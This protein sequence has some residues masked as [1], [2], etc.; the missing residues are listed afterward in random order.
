MTCMYVRIEIAYVD[1]RQYIQISYEVL[2]SVDTILKEAIGCCLCRPLLYW[3]DILD[4]DTSLWHLSLIPVTWQVYRW[5]PWYWYQSITP[6]FALICLPFYFV[7]L[8]LKALFELK[9]QINVELWTLYGHPWYWYQSMTP[10]YDT[11]H[12]IGIQVTSL[13]LIPFYNTCL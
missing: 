2:K 8:G 5:H 7:N 4:I 1:E 6:V 12:L 10:V 3:H 11:C 13:I 9:R